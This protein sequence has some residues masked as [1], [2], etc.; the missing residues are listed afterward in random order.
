M[1][2]FEEV[3]E[4]YKFWILL[5]AGLAVFVDIFLLESTLD[6]VILFVT[7][8]WV[9]SIRLCKFEGRVSIAAALGFLAFCPFLLIFGKETVAEKAAIWAYIFLGL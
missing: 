9:F 1:L 8:L 2:S 3:L 5:F 7:G 6:L 4:K